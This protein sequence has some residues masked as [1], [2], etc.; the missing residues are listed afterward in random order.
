MILVGLI[1]LLFLHLR[2]PA[3][4]NPALNLEFTSKRGQGQRSRKILSAV[5]S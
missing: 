4:R 5:S 1:Y 2:S 3:N